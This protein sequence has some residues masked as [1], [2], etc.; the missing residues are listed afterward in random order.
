M[1]T[2]QSRLSRAAPLFRIGFLALIQFVAMCWST[3]AN[4]D[5][6]WHTLRNELLDIL[7]EWAPADSTKKA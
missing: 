4:P 6:Q 2:H 3:E 5:A 1:I 7:A